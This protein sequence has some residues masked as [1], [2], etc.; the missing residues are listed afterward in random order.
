M[1]KH[2]W[3][4]ATYWPVWLVLFL[5]TFG[6]REGLAL[7]SGRPGDTLS[8]WVWRVLRITSNETPSH[9]SAVDYLVFGAWVTVFTWLT[10][11]FFFRRF[12]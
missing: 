5:G 8:D 11:H 4:A 9:W 12:T 10:W 3:S 2:A 6:V 1:L 7:A